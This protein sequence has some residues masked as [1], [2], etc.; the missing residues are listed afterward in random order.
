MGF[1]IVGESTRTTLGQQATLLSR[2]CQ[3]PI[4][5]ILRQLGLCSRPQQQRVLLMSPKPLAWG[6]SRHLVDVHANMLSATAR[7]T[8][9]WQVLSQREADEA[10]TAM[11]KGLHAPAVLSTPLST[12]A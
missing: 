11:A 3:I 9:H 7:Q 12:A 2:A 8:L 1:A 10:L 4:T 5:S 6:V